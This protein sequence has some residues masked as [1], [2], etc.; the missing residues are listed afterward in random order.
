METFSFPGEKVEGNTFL[1][2]GKKSKIFENFTVREKVGIFR[3]FPQG[4]KS[5]PL[6][7][8]DS[9]VSLTVTGERKAGFSYCPPSFLPLS[10][11]KEIFSSFKL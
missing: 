9:I 10:V 5:T 2:L 11:T 8:G 7:G 4:R 1:S 6:K 3:E